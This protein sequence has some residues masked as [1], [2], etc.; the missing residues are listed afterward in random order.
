[1]KPSDILD[2][3]GLLPDDLLEETMNVRS[4]VIAV[5]AAVKKPYSF[6]RCILIAAMV[7]V[8]MAISAVALYRRWRMPQ[9]VNQFTGNGIIE[10][11]KGTYPVPT[12]P[13]ST[14]ES[15][16]TVEDDPESGSE[17]RQ[18]EW[19][20]EQALQ[21]LQTVNKKDY[22]AGHIEITRLHNQWWGREEVEVTFKAND[23]SDFQITFDAESGNLIG[24]TGFE[25]HD[26]EGTPMSE[27]NA[28]AQA[29]QWYE[30]LPYAKGYEF[31]SIT[32]YDDHAWKFDFTKQRELMVGGKKVAVSCDYESVGITIDPT[33]GELLLSE[34]FY[35][36]LL[37]DHETDEVPLTQEQAVD[38]VNQK[39]LLAEPIEQYTVEADAAVCLPDLAFAA[40]QNG[41]IHSAG[42]YPNCDVTRLGWELTF[43]NSSM[44]DITIAVDMYTGEILSV[45]GTR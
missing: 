3:V 12:V 31:R 41:G 30:L 38:V 20:T 34:C 26:T 10:H 15:A 45:S 9:N 6:L 21:V 11:E 39:N 24:I 23:T 29:K 4:Q 33:T 35:V 8:L 18:D 32:K 27:E 16:G 17:E 25:A 44:Q 22:S 36:P 1:M 5:Q 14:E 28:L 40:S 42:A 43:S 7:A 19:F 37:D 13:V 2:A